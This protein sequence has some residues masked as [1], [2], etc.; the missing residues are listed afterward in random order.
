MKMEVLPPIIRADQL[1]NIATVNH[2]M[3]LF[4]V[5]FWHHALRLGLIGQ[6]ALGIHSTIA[7]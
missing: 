4:A 3:H 6:T 7:Q 2:V 5:L 1:T